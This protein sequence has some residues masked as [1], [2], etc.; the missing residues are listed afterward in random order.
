MSFT[1]RLTRDSGGSVNF[2]GASIVFHLE[3]GLYVPNDGATFTEDVVQGGFVVE[4]LP[5]F[6]RTTIPAG[7]IQ[8]ENDKIVEFLELARLWKKDTV[9]TNAIWFEYY[10]EGDAPVRRLVMGGS[11]QRVGLPGMPASLEGSRARGQLILFLSPWQEELSLTSVLSGVSL[12]QAGGF[13]TVVGGGNRQGRLFLEIKGAAAPNQPIDRGW[14]G[15]RPTRDG[16]SAFNPDW[17]V[18]LASNLFGNSVNAGIGTGGGSVEFT[19][20][21]S[22]L[23]PVFAIEV[24]DISAT[25]HEHFYGDYSVLALVRNT[26]TASLTFGFQI[27]WGVDSQSINLAQN[28][29]VF[30]NS[31][32]DEFYWLEMGEINIPGHSVRTGGVFFVT[33]F[34]IE[35]SAEIVSGV[36]AGNLYVDKLLL[37]PKTHQVKLSG[38]TFLSGGV[39]T[40]QRTQW[41]I[42]RE[43]NETINGVTNNSESVPRIRDIVEVE[44]SD[45]YMPVEGGKLVFAAGQF[46]SS[47]G[48]AIVDGTA[49]PATHPIDLDLYKRWEGWQDG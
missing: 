36:F 43:A 38:N 2:L 9:R 1:A 39:P 23:S 28:Q 5:L 48:A 6:A 35:F 21:A 27:K 17:D 45:F 32:D 10:A 20:S 15:I 34:Q 31:L 7:T 42:R 8:D 37:V 11:F 12:A 41:I 16:D 14:A 30:I 26:V 49:G 24:R 29:E 33:N 22:G 44:D 4:T 19:P 46:V 40:N 18:S 3:Y 25:D 13:T 47:V